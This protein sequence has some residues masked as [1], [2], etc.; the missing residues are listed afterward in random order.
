M[1]EVF[2]S[3]AEEDGDIARAIAAGLEQ[4]DYSTWY[5]ERDSVLG[6]NYLWQ[7]G[8]AIEKAP[9]FLLLVSPKS[10]GSRQVTSEVVRAFECGKTFLPVLDNLTHAE[11]QRQQPVWRQAVGAAASVRIPSGGVAAV[12]PNILT[13][14]RNLSLKPVRPVTDS[15]ALVGE[16][17]RETATAKQV[18]PRAAGLQHLAGEVRNRTIQLLHTAAQTELTWVPRGTSNHIL[19]HAGHGLWVQDVLCLLLVTGSSELPEGWEEMFKMG[20]RPA[21]WSR[22]WPAKEELLVQ[23][24]AQLPRLLKCIGD[25]SEAD[26]DRKPR[27]PHPG[28]RRSLWESILHGLHDEAAHQGEMYLLLKLQRLAVTAS[29]R[30]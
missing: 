25:L 28:D 3:Y 16:T 12:L 13:G 22:P 10:I 27:Y 20:S 18:S 11:F 6:A 29:W 2:I 5:Y 8:E 21:S 17:V 23:L 4:Y 15:A 24:K 9:V 14:L 30:G 1:A 7:T 19:W 26:L